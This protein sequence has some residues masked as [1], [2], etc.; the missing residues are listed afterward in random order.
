MSKCKCNCGC[1]Y[2]DVCPICFTGITWDVFDGYNSATGFFARPEDEYRYNFHNMLYQIYKSGEDDSFDRCPIKGRAY[3]A[4]PFLRE[5]GCCED[6]DANGLSGGCSGLGFRSHIYHRPPRDT[7]EVMK[8]GARPGI[9]DQYSPVF[10]DAT[11]NARVS[12]ASDIF[13]AKNLPN[14]TPGTG[15]YDGS[16]SGIWATFPYTYLANNSLCKGSYVVTIKDDNGPF[17]SGFYATHS[18]GVAGIPGARIDDGYWSK[19]IETL[20]QFGSSNDLDAFGYFRINPATLSSGSFTKNYQVDIDFTRFGDTSSDASGTQITLTG[21]PERRMNESGEFIY[22]YETGTY[23]V[24]QYDGYGGPHLL[25]QPHFKHNARLWSRHDIRPF[26]GNENSSQILIYSVKENSSK[27]APN[28]DNGWINYSP[29]QSVESG[30][31]YYNDASVY[32]LVDHWFGDE[33][34]KIGKVSDLLGGYQVNINFSCVSGAKINSFGRSV[35]PMSGDII[36]PTLGFS[37]S[38]TF[39]FIFDRC[40]YGSAYVE[41]YGNMEYHWGGYNSKSREEMHRNYFGSTK[42]KFY[43]P[44]GTSPFA[45]VIYYGEPQNSGMA[46][47]YWST[48][49]GNDWATHID[50][51]VTTYAPQSGS[52]SLDTGGEYPKSKGVTACIDRFRLDG[53]FSTAGLVLD[54]VTWHFRNSELS[55]TNTQ[56]LS[57]SDDYGSYTIPNG[58]VWE[59]GGSGVGSGLVSENDLCTFEFDNIGLESGTIS[60]W[61]LDHTAGING[62][63]VVETGLPLSGILRP[64]QKFEFGF[65]PFSGFSLNY[66]GVSPKRTDMEFYNDAS[67]YLVPDPLNFAVVVYGTGGVAPPPPP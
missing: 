61:T 20:P 48:A 53:D 52:R 62:S 58:V 47:T 26:L 51:T 56:V 9:N 19:D 18:D 54:K 8:A 36:I 12:F 50:N 45:W 17:G 39:N 67:G 24:T 34:Q 29:Y 15:Y 63:G 31:P 32:I 59:V 46:G 57:A 44:F 16:V 43:D 25:A 66:P 4:P 27:Y 30:L 49:N 11:G 1:S 28:F 40:M 64:F 37:G 38:K 2:A 3:K 23:N 13:S 6:F 5:N 60:G 42:A 35:V 22:A 10:N 21:V 55:V 14:A 41:A 7:I 33:P 65:V